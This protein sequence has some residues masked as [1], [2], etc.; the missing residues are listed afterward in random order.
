MKELL[1]KLAKGESTVE[2][3]LKAI[4]DSEK[5]KVPRFRLNDKIEEVKELQQQLKERDTQLEELGKKAKD[6]EELVSE[7]N[8]LKEENK[9]TAKELQEKLEKQAF[10]FNLEKAL[11]DAKAKNPKA[12]KALLNTEAIKLDG[13]KMLGLE[14]QLKS[15]QESD[16]YLFGDG[17]PAG[18]KGRKP[19]DD[20]T[21]P[22][23]GIS[24]ERFNQMNY[25]ERVEL[26]N[27]QPETYKQL[28][29]GNE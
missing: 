12:V 21:P 23:T 14:E 18:L 9:Q 1:E 28:I 10:D 16:S 25:K 24:K 8:K 26:F 20:Q 11:S 22:N 13:D 27:T 2:D 5:E 6:N 7:I 3:V 17:E 29:G 19:N 15:L 4:D